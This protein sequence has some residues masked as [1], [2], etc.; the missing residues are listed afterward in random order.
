MNPHSYKKINTEGKVILY[1]KKS[2]T[3]CRGNDGIRKSLFGN[4]QMII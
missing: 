3:K 4:Y 1:S 2:I